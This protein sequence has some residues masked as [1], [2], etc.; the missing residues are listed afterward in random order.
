MENQNQN[1]N[2]IEDFISEP[3]FYCTN[4]LSLR[5]RGEIKGLEYCDECG[6]TAI[7]QCS[8]EEWEQKYKEKTGHKF[9]DEY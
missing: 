1:N 9:L 5:V 2:Q 6:S 4:C 8:I 3:V 7:G